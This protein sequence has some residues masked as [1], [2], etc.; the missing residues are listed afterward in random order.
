MWLFLWL[1]IVSGCL[2]HL[3]KRAPHTLVFWLPQWSFF[4]NFMNNLTKILFVFVI[5]NL[6]ALLFDTIY[7]VVWSNW[8]SLFQPRYLTYWV[9]IFLSDTRWW[10]RFLWLQV[11]GCQTRYSTLK[12]LLWCLNKFLDQLIFLIFLS[13]FLLILN[14]VISLV[15]Q[16]LFLQLTLNQNL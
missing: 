1:C 9:F 10:W 4:F 7:N 11:L 15:F 12:L 5:Y 13:S 6:S 2:F 3:R 16:L 14:V 8:I